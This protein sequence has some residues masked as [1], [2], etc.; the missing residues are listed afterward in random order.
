MSRTPLELTIASMV[1]NIAAIRAEVSHEVQH[2]GTDDEF[3]ERA[4]I[5]FDVAGDIRV[6][7]NRLVVVANDDRHS[8]EVAT[9]G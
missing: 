1:E 4:A 3:P 9:R 6:A 5:L 7:V 8:R 2:A